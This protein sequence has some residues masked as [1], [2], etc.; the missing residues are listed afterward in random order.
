MQG[1][2]FLVVK[3]TDF[4]PYYPSAYLIKTQRVGKNS[5]FVISFCILGVISVILS[6]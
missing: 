4:K 6:G 5:L 1:M 3:T 2:E